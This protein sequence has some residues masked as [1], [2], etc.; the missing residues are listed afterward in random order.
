MRDLN[1]LFLLKSQVHP[2]FNSLYVSCLKD[3]WTNIVHFIILLLLFRYLPVAPFTQIFCSICFY[4]SC[5]SVI[6]HIVNY[7]DYNWKWFPGKTGAHF[8]DNKEFFCM[9]ISKKFGINLPCV[10]RFPPEIL[11]QCFA[12]RVANKIMLLYYSS[13]V[14]W[15]CPLL[16]RHFYPHLR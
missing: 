10:Q 1:Y 14:F 15:T 13:T 2:K 9:V 3:T 12:I 4:V 16:S 7:I 5:F 8:L 6:R 11:G